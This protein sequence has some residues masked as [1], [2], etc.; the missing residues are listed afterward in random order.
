MLAFV[1]PLDSSLHAGGRLVCVAVCGS[2]G[3]WGRASR[4]NC[5]SISCVEGRWYLST[6]CVA[7]LAHVQIA[8]NAVARCLW[9][10]RFE[11]LTGG[12]G[13]G[14]SGE[15]T[16]LKSNPIPWAREGV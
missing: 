12:G 7:A 15:I 4:P 13:S 1:M 5:S 11:S 9:C 6:R 14:G 8:S 10:T 2:R 16:G 3:Q